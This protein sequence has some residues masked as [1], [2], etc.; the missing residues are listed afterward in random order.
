MKLSNIT[1]DDLSS[2]KG[3][4]RITLT[5]DGC[6][7]EISREVKEI[8]R[9]IKNGN[10]TAFC[11]NTCQG[12]KLKINKI[13][14][15]EYCG[16]DFTYNFPT[17]KYCNKSCSNFN[18][19]ITKETKQR[20]SISVSKIPRN[21]KK[22]PTKRLYNKSITKPKKIKDEVGEFEKIFICK[23]K[24]C[25]FVGSYRKQTGYCNNCKHCYTE[26][27]RAKF[28][29]TFNVYHYPDL[30]DIEFIN[31][32]GWRKTKGSNINI[33]GVSRDHKVSVRDAIKFNYDPYYIKHPLNC[34]LMLHSEN[35]SKGTQSS[36]TYDELVA[37]VDSY[38][39]IKNA[40]T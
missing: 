40:S 22:S 33:N 39:S 9:C 10:T 28:I 2:L 27:G 6:Q 16:E 15:C 30:F 35:Q 31:K 38:D 18:R 13:K 29:F 4:S 20:I 12:K 21:K 36:I 8:R 24:N 23:C 26:N 32:H 3:R 7:G 11:S 14:Q 17:Q 1:L 37:M 34:E 5:C 19:E 25:S